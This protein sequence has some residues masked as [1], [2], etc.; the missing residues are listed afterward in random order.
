VVSPQDGNVQIT[1]N[2]GSSA[3]FLSCALFARVRN[4]LM[5]QLPVLE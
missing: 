5:Y 1:C 2:N 4:S 3:S